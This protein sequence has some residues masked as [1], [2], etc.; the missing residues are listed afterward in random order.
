[1][2]GMLKR[3]VLRNIHRAFFCAVCAFSVSVMG[4]S[5]SLQM[6]LPERFSVV[7]GE[8]LEFKNLPI[9]A[10]AVKTLGGNDVAQV[11]NSA[12]NSYTTQLKLPL[13]VAVKQVKVDVIERETVVPSGMPFGIKMFTDGVMVVSMENVKTKNGDKNPAADAGIEAGDIIL[14]ADGREVDGNEEFSN[15]INNSN[16]SKVCLKIKRRDKIMEKVISP[17][18]G[19]GRKTGIKIRLPTQE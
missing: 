17:V 19:E 1:M 4:Y 6:S 5:V 10:E 3:T 2:Q 9:E 15:M 8:T 14:S 11:Y 13:G 7:Q 12:G 18:K 16:G